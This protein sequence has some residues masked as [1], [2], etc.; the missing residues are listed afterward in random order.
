MDMGHRR[1]SVWIV[2]GCWSHGAKHGRCAHDSSLFDRGNAGFGLSDLP[3]DEGGLVSVALVA[4]SSV[5]LALYRSWD[6]V[7]YGPNSGTAITPL[8]AWE[9][10]WRGSKAIHD[11]HDL[12]T[13]TSG[14]TLF[15]FMPFHSL[16]D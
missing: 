4:G 14:V 2:L 12:T 8:Q 13:I 9:M 3:W 6:G 1:D 15:C 16:L 7:A 10:A 5:N 11:Q